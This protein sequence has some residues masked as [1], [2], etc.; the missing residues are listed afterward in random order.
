MEAYES[1]WKF[2]QVGGLLW[3]LFEVYETRA[4]R[5]KY[6]GCMEARGSFHRKWP[7]TLHLM[8]LREA[9]TFADSGNFYLPPSTSNEAS[10]VKILPWK[11]KNEVQR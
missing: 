8:E 6:I 2:M 1:S 9:S 7:W 5:R 3:K 10:K 4:I 11:R